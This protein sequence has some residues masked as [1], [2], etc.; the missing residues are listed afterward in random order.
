[1][2]SAAVCTVF[3]TKRCRSNVVGYTGF[4]SERRGVEVSVPMAM[5][6]RFRSVVS[7]VICRRSMEDVWFMGV[8]VILRSTAGVCECIQRQILFS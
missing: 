3:P 7:G 5:T 2:S 4:I 8:I 1:M 6:L